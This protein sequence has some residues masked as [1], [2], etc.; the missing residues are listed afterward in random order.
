M[1]PGLFLLLAF[2]AAL[3]LILLTLGLRGRQIN[4]HPTC[5]RCKFDLVGVYPGIERCPECGAGVL[6]EDEPLVGI[7][8]RAPKLAIS[9]SVLLLIAM[10]VSSVV[11]L[12]VAGQQQLARY[13]PRPVLLWQLEHGPA[14]PAVAAIAE[15]ERRAMAGASTRELQ[16]AANAVLARHADPGRDW[17]P[18]LGS[19][20][21][22]RFADGKLPTKDFVQY[23]DQMPNWLVVHQPRVHPG[24]A[25]DLGMGIRIGSGLDRGGATTSY[26]LVCSLLETRIGGLPQELQAFQREA[27]AKGMRDAWWPTGLGGSSYASALPPQRIAAVQAEPGR[28][29]V[30]TLWRMELVD[31]ATDTI[32]TTWDRTERTDLTIVPPDQPLTALLPPDPETERRLRSAISLSKATFLPPVGRWQYLQVT[33]QVLNPPVDCAWCL[34]AVIDGGR[35]TPER[36]LGG[37]ATSRAIPEGS[38]STGQYHFFLEL[39]LEPVLSEDSRV[40]LVLRPDPERASI[41][42]LDGPIWGG[43]LAFEDVPIVPDPDR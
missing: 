2:S 25:M 35:I 30:E 9:G 18:R 10:M 27:Y 42:R 16:A 14:N 1:F 8:K 36:R 32:L 23:I 20:I 5:R 15:L 37:I 28:A 13:L 33:F 38:Y 4:D 19:F 24:S 43:E 40:T 11:L 31:T 29:T 17:D 41:D 3:G 7:R 12:P 39:G 21:E 22:Q 26:G 34:E 6:D